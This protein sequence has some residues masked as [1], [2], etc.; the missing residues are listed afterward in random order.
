MKFVNR[1]IVAFMLVTLACAAAFAKGKSQTI[2]FSSD[3]R[4][5]GT[6]VK[7]GTYTVAFDETTGELSVLKGGKLIAKTVARIEKRERK[8]QSIEFRTRQAVMGI[9]LASVAFGGSDQN[10]VVNQAGMEAGN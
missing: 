1:I 6:L 8:A 10:L 2:Y 3:L 7:S 5:S 9:E 4:V